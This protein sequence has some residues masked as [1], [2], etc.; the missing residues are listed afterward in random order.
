M[1]VCTL[2][3]AQDCYC[4]NS[5]ILFSTTTTP[6]RRDSL[7]LDAPRPP[8]TTT[9]DARRPM[10]RTTRRPT[11][12]RRR[13]TRRPLAQIS[14][15]PPGSSKAPNREPP[16]CEQA[17]TPRVE[18]PARHRALLWW[19]LAAPLTLLVPPLAQAAV[20]S[21]HL[22]AAARSRQAR[23]PRATTAWPDPQP[24][25][26]QCLRRRA[27]V[28]RALPYVLPDAT[29][30]TLAY[31]S[32]ALTFCLDGILGTNQGTT[33]ELVQRALRRRLTTDAEAAFVRRLGWLDAF[34]QRWG[35]TYPPASDD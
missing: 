26:D 12:R 34:N 35:P 15:L 24:V 28:L 19:A 23:P 3:L 16:A 14:R 31:G 21:D 11:P 4:E 18:G 25:A 7:R 22:L 29:R 6:S 5:P 17:H 8:P 9:L 32:Y 20:A 27:R 33:G 30:L 10:G 2:T 13:L 1:C